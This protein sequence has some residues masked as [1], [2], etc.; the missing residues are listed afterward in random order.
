MSSAKGRGQSHIP[1]GVTCLP[2]SS[3]FSAPGKMAA[4]TGEAFLRAMNHARAILS[5]LRSF[6]WRAAKTRVEP[7]KS[8]SEG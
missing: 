2:F 5:S 1:G 3:S 7:T 4:I 8:S 6:W